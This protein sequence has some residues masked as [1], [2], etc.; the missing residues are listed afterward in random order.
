MYF[1]PLNGFRRE[2]SRGRLYNVWNTASVRALRKDISVIGTKGASTA[3]T[4]RTTRYI[5]HDFLRVYGFHEVN[6]KGRF[7]A[8]IFYLFA[9]NVVYRA[10]RC[11]VVFGYVVGF[12]VRDSVPFC[13]MFSLMLWH[14][15]PF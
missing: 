4:M 15:I 9:T 3:S 5:Y 11:F 13:V 12:L 1:S 10:L 8:T 6:R 14:G 7:I 2:A